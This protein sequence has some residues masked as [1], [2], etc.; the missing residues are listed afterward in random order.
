MNC[1]EYFS[2]LSDIFFYVTNSKP[3]TNSKT[4]W[5]TKIF[6]S[7]NTQYKLFVY[8]N[9]PSN[10]IPKYRHMRIEQFE[11]KSLCSYKYKT[12]GLVDA[13]LSTKSNEYEISYISL[14]SNNNSDNDMIRICLLNFVYNYKWA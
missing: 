13:G 2:E 8:E 1:T 12:V 10:G 14:D 3:N 9:I 7:S 5:L 11:G 6:D 4:K